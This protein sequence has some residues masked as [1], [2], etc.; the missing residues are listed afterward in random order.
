MTRCA[1]RRHSWAPFSFV[2]WGRTCSPHCASWADEEAVQYRAAA[3][4]LPGLDNYCP[5][6]PAW[7]LGTGE[8]LVLA[9]PGHCQSNPRA[10]LQCSAVMGLL[11]TCPR[12]RAL[13]AKCCLAAQARKAVWACA[14]AAL[15]LLSAVGAQQQSG[16]GAPGG[17]CRSSC[18]QTLTSMTGILLCCLARQG[19]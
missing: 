9:A 13:P 5:Q 6:S 10:C 3:G 1:L 15:L 11:Y 16:S 4:P 14:A 19:S 18:C 2:R 12:A 8:R 7:G 17:A